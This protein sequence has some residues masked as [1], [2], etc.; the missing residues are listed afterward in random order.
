MVER[1]RLKP[2]QWAKLDADWTKFVD[3]HFSV[4]KKKR[5]RP[6]KNTDGEFFVIDERGTKTR[7][8]SSLEPVWHQACSAGSLWCHNT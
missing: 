7:V 8:I 1:S 6:R 3:A 2:S 5:G 4:A